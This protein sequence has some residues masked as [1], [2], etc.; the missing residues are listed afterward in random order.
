[1]SAREKSMHVRIDGHT[2]GDGGRLD[3]HVESTGQ[4]DPR[5]FREDESVLPRRSTHARMMPPTD[6]NGR[7]LA[8]LIRELSAESGDLVRQEIDLAKAEMRE[9]MSIFTHGMVSM[10]IGGALLFCALLTGLG[11]L[12]GGL[13]SLLAQFLSVGVAVWLSPLILTVVLGVVGWMLISGAKQRMADEGLAMRRTA[14]TLK[15][16]SRWAKVKAHEVKEEVTHV[17]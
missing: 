3:A 1:M 9:K 8:E 12:N 11:A 14:A 5:L 17:R 15:A 4:V 6:G 16:D 2:N 10:G 7:S 13:T